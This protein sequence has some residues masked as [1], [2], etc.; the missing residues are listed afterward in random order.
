[1]EPW[2]STRPAAPFVT[3]DEILGSHSSEGETAQPP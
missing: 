1:M 3:Q 2:H